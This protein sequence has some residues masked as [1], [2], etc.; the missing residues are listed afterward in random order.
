MM[1]LALELAQLAAWI[2]GPMILIFTLA[3]GCGK[4]QDWRNP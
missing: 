4:F 3:W 2:L 1:A